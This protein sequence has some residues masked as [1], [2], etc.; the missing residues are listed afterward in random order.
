MKDTKKVSDIH[1]MNDEGGGHTSGQ[2]DNKCPEI[3]EVKSAFHVSVFK[4]VKLY[5][6]VRFTH[7]KTNSAIVGCVLRTKKLIQREDNKLN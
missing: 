2:K 3:Y 4:C 1:A 6:R 7:Q 5:R